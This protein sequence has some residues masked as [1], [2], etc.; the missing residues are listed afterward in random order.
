MSGQLDGNFLPGSLPHKFILFLTLI[1]FLVVNN[2]FFSLYTNLFIIIIKLFLDS[3]GGIVEGFTVVI[4]VVVVV[5]VVVFVSGQQQHG[6]IIII[7][8]INLDL[9]LFIWTVFSY[10]LRRC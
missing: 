8:C 9:D 6:I 7:N 2:C 1:T 5:G 4:V 3:R 10:S